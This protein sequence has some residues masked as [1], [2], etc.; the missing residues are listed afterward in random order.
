ME[1]LNC[2]C[3]WSIRTDKV[4]GAPDSHTL[5]CP[6]CKARLRLGD[7]RSES[8]AETKSDRPD[9]GPANADAEISSGASFALFMHGP[10]WGL[11][12]TLWVI[13]FFM[14]IRSA[15]TISDRIHD[16]IAFFGCAWL[17]IGARRWARDLRGRADRR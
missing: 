15:D 2:K 12:V 3:G 13:A 11:C 9:A 5:K 10:A 8:A 6:Q 7:L 17:A 16:Q 4:S 14:L 1:T